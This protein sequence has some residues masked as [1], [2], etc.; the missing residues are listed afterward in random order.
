[1]KKKMTD[2]ALLNYRDNKTVFV[3][4]SSVIQT[5]VSQGGLAI[6]NIFDILKYLI[7]LKIN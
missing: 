6:Y 4:N 3:I 1:M 5:I 7:Y 2:F